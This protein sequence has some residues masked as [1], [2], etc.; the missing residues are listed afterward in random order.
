MKAALQARWNGWL[1]RAE[2]RLPALTRLRQPEPLPITLDRRRIYVLPTPFGL[3]F[4]ALLSLMGL[5]ALNYDNNPALI[6]V[7]LLGSAAHTGLLQAFLALRGLRL[8]GVEAEPVHAGQPLSLRFRF[9]STEPRRRDGLRLTRGEQITHFSLAAEGDLDVL[10]SLPTQRR[11]WQRVER[12]SLSVRRPLG[13][14]V[15][16]SWLHPERA[17]LVYPRTEPNGPPLPADASDGAPQRRRSPD[18]EVHGLRDYR[19][20]DPLRTVAWKRSAQRGELLVREFESPRGRDAVLDWQALTPLDTEA[21]IR[22]LTHWLI[23]AERQ[24]LRSE[25]RLPDG[26]LG[27]GKGAAHLHA[28]LSRLALLPGAEG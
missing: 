23:E 14:F 13:M 10:L 28:C 4:G 15:A 26:R 17:V 18:E 8:Q 22:R 21:R 12:I 16:W 25:L 5:G 24:G 2:A 3:A 19:V 6:L 11:G 1:Q 7:F 20:G 27:P 9:A